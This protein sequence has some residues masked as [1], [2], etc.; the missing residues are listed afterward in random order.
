MV[1]KTNTMTTAKKS[2]TSRSTPML[3]GRCI[4]HPSFL[5]EQSHPYFVVHDLHPSHTHPQ[6]S[7]LCPLLSTPSVYYT[8]GS[9]E[10]YIYWSFYLLVIKFSVCQCPRIVH[11][12]I[13]LFHF[14]LFYTIPFQE[15][16]LLVIITKWYCS[17]HSYHG[18]SCLFVSTYWVY[19]YVNI[20]TIFVVV[21]LQYYYC[22][23]Y[24]RCDCMT[25]KDYRRH[26][27]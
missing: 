10:P 21:L 8:A 6:T 22:L 5:T 27:I 17:P 25:S 26:L 4:S 1:P 16:G 15:F 12:S 7:V 14:T 11:D 24:S 23:P 19:I 13:A 2:M 18:V 20:I 3:R 9:V